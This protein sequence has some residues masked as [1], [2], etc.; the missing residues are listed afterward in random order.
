MRLSQSILSGRT[1]ERR[2]HRSRIPI[3]VSLRHAFSPEQLLTEC[4]L[5]DSDGRIRIVIPEIWAQCV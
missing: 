4:S 5:G 1:K 3:F 2:S